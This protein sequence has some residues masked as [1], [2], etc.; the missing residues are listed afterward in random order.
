MPELITL[1]EAAGSVLWGKHRENS[2]ASALVV[3]GLCLECLHFDQLKD[4]T[5]KPQGSGA[6]LVLPIS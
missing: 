1:S 3:C 4:G 2:G 6:P 5:N